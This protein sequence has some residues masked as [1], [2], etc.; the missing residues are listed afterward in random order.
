VK[1]KIPSPAR[2][3]G[4]GEGETV[5]LVPGFDEYFIAYTDRSEVLDKQYAKELNQGGGM[6]NG[7]IVVNGKM[8]GGWRR[9]FEKKS[10]VISIRLFEKITPGQQELLKKQTEAFGRFINLPVVV[11]Q[12]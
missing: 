7:A 6:V 8:C 10:V 1:P 3:E 4:Q 2:G 9:T 12:S 5:Y 11:K